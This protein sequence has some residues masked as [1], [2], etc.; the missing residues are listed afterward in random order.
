MLGESPCISDRLLAFCWRIAML[1][2]YIPGTTMM[3]IC[4]ALY[5]IL[6]NYNTQLYIMRTCVWMSMCVCVCGWVGGGLV[7]GVGVRQ[8]RLSRV[9]NIEAQS[10]VCAA[11][12]DSIWIS[13]WTTFNGVIVMYSVFLSFDAQRRVLLS[14]SEVSD[15][16]FECTIH[17][18]YI[19]MLIRLVGFIAFRGSLTRIL[20][21]SRRRLRHH[22]YTSPCYK[23]FTKL[24]PC[25]DTIYIYRSLYYSPICGWMCI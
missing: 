4:H 19:Y 3:I 17:I 1:Y 23:M 14:I 16:I 21:S 12:G 6:H 22:S 10:A 18:V 5:N 9:V 8:A 2:K 13:F 25:T 15:H 11:S 24:Y 20:T 7:W